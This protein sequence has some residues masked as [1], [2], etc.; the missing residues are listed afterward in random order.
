MSGSFSKRQYAMLQTFCDMRPSEYMSINDAMHWDQRPFRSML[1]RK[2]VVYKHNL[3]FCATKAGREAMQEFL[4]FDNARQ[5]PHLP[6]TATFYTM[7]PTR[8]RLR[9]VAA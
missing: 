2:W 7:F 5:N 4:H 1:L 6:L 3:G 8:K 9:A